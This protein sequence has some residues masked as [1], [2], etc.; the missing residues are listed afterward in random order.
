MDQGQG[1]EV[2]GGTVQAEPVAL[3][4]EGQRGGEHRARP[5]A[6]EAPGVLEENPGPRISAPVERVGEPGEALAAANAGQPDAG[7]H[8]RCRG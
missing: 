1:A 7:D 4:D 5:A 2:E 8:G 3:L 6:A